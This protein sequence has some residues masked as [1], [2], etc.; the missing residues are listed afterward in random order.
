MRHLP[1]AVHKTQIPEVT[2]FFKRYVNIDPQKELCPVRPSCHYHMG[3]VPTNEFGQVQDRENNI[4]DGLFAIGECAA[5]SF[6]GFNR[7]GTNSILELITMGKFAADRILALLD[8]SCPDT[9]D[10]GA[11]AAIERFE[12]YLQDN[13]IGKFGQNQINHAPGNDGAFVRIS[14]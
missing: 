4:V 11:S 10:P 3:G 12:G 9:A 2:S 5:A 14:N 7:L 6:H 13:R 1:E 8:D